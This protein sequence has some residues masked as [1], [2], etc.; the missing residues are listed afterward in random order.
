[1]RLASLVILLLLAGTI[2]IAC[3]GGPGSGCP[4]AVSDGLGLAVDRRPDHPLIADATVQLAQA[5]PVYIEYGNDQARW[6]RTPTTATDTSHRLPILRLR[7]NTTY[8]VRAFAMDAAGCMH[9]AAQ[10][11]FATGELPRLFRKMSVTMAGS[12]SSPLTITDLKL[13]DNDQAEIEELRVLV[14][15][16]QEGQ[17]VW[18]HPISPQPARGSHTDSVMGLLQLDSGNL[19]YLVE[20]FGVEEIAPDGRLVKRIGME[21]ARPH[22]DLLD[23]HDGRVLILGADHRVID[24]TRNGGRP[25]QKVRGDALWLLD[26]ESGDKQQVW[27]V[28]EALDPTE[29]GPR[30]PE[31]RP[32]E[33]RESPDVFD[34]THS[35]SVAMGARGNLLISIRW[36]DQIISLS[37]DFKT[38]EWKLGGPGS[39][40]TFPDASDRF[41]AQHS[42]SEAANG[43]ILLFD[44]GYG[45]PD[46]DYSRALELKLDFA[47]MAAGKAWEY[48]HQPE[49]YSSRI[50]NAVRLPSGNTLVNFG[51]PAEPDDPVVVV[52]ARPDGTAASTLATRLKGGRRTSTYRAYSLDSLGGERPV[53]R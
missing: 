43:N 2:L 10:A 44:N 37:P 8:Q 38:V 36:L 20:Y 34:W 29:R 48:R 52:E 5:A 18:Y 47:T 39:S 13:R 21:D 45:R 32:L 30:P 33:D 42:A 31:Y 15:F 51:F 19:L 26:L 46:G 4:A 12:P 17:V 24:D 23:L 1:M 6:L 3:T 7:P 14:A 50:S 49:A 22:H 11:E 35:N 25:D 41:Y 9:R 53:P 16:D 40:F 27:S 28:F